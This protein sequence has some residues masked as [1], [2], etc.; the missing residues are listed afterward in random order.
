LRRDAKVSGWGLD[1]GGAGKIKV[2]A[3][4]DFRCSHEVR[5]YLDE[6]VS[7]IDR[8]YFGNKPIDGYRSSCLSSRGLP[9]LL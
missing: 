7:A 5:G 2:T 8:L 9:D 6:E 1:C 4:L 3:S